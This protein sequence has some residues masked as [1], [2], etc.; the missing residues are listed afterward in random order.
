MKIFKSS[1]IFLC[2]ICAVGFVAAAT[3]IIKQNMI[4]ISI[5]D[6]INSLVNNVKYKNPV[7]I[8]NIP[9]INII[10]VSANNN[11]Y[12]EITQQFPD[13]KITQYKNIKNSELIDK[14][15]EALSRNMPVICPY[16]A[17]DLESGSE[18]ENKNKT[19]GDPENNEKFT[20]VWKMN[21]CIVKEINIP[22]DKIKVN[23]PYGDTETYTIKDFLKATRF[24]NYENMEFYL[25]LGFAVEV[26]TKNTVYIFEKLE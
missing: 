25:K 4:D 9:A 21:Y 1:V 12:S 8:K 10:S 17:V 15:Y 6:S 14:I 5:N 24:E 2:I 22:G 3:M 23:N 16:A 11:F 20:P 26:F 13:Y 19:K 7:K 18:I